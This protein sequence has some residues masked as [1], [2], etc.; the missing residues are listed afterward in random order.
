MRSLKIP[1]K[2]KL[3]L[4]NPTAY[5]EV[6][7]YE[8]LFSHPRATLDS[9]AHETV[10]SGR[11]PHE[12][13]VER[14]GFVAPDGVE[15]VRRWLDGNVRG[16]ELTIWG[17]R[18]WPGR[19]MSSRRPAPVL[20]HL[21][22]AGLLASRNVAVIGSRR[23]TE[24]GRLRAARIA[25]EL[26]RAGVSVTTGLAEG[27][28]TAAT[29]AALQCGGHPMAVIGTPIDSCYPKDNWHLQQNVADLGL[30]VS[31]VPLYRYSHEHFEA[32]RAYFPE[33]NEL[34]SALCDATV[35]VEAADRSGILI[36]ARFCLDQG[37]P[38]FIMRSAA[39]N[40]SVSWPADF[41]GKDGVHIL[42]ST[43]ELLSIVYGR[44]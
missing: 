22:N 15:T 7:A 26:T 2:G 23:A 24:K 38:L 34:M 25:R 21:G 44:H 16:L 4:G 3:A 32:R 6:V 5:D 31:Q 27:I 30:V 37:R 28:D 14:F 10:L 42:D 17:G 13:L 12:A 39:E 11:T 29:E 43:E 19:L 35:I 41:L 1:A 33:R 20:Y 8:Y 18:E 36:Q 40:L 9:I